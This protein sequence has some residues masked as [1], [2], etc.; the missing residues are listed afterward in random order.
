[1]WSVSEN[2][3][4]AID[5]S[6]TKSFILPVRYG[7]RV[8]NVNIWKKNGKRKIC[9]LRYKLLR[10]DAK[11]PVKATE[12]SAGFDLFAAE[13]CCIPSSEVGLIK[14]GLALACPNGTY[15]T[16]SDRS[17]IACRHNLHVLAGVIDSDYRGEIKIVMHNFGNKPMYVGMHMKVAQIVI[18]K[19]VNILDIIECKEGLNL[20][21]RGENG[22]G[23]SGTD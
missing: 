2:V 3:N 1:M 9:T 16:I 10:S 8:V 13:A 12:G 19:I 11:P 18:H 4:A 6:Q 5:H 21:S 22:F 20:T 14:T 15:G 23:S 17:S 7:A